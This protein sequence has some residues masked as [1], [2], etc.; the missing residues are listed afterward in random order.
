M[1]RAFSAASALVLSIGTCPEPPKKTFLS[2]PLKPGSVKYSLFAR[3]VTRRGQTNG[4]KKLSTTARW[5]PA[6]IAGPDDGCSPGLPPSAD[7]SAAGSAP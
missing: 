7:P 6:K 1:L 4:R 5:F 2:Q 3:N